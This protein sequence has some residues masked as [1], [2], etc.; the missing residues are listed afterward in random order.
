MIN[1][2]K[3]FQLKKQNKPKKGK[4][5]KPWL[6]LASAGA[7]LR[8]C[9][10]IPEHFHNIKA[11]FAWF[12]ARVL[13]PLQHQHHHL[14]LQHQNH[15]FLWHQDHHLFHSFI[16]HWAVAMLSRTISLLASQQLRLENNEESKSNNGEVW[17]FHWTVGTWRQSTRTNSSQLMKTVKSVM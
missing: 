7:E 12:P 1:H 4:S 14:F 9:L 15:L 3:N 6:T 17:T 10:R 16:Y 11:T 5:P 2:S 13:L 8:W